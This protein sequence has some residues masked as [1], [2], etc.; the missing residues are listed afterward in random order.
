[1]LAVMMAKMVGDI[2]N[3]S[4]YS[5]LLRLKCIPYLDV[6]PFVHHRKER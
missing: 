3:V 6:E 5:S 4:L 1:M 2:F